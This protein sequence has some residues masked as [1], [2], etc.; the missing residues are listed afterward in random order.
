[1]RGY[2]LGMRLADVLPLVPDQLNRDTLTSIRQRIEPE[3]IEEALTRAKPIAVRRRKLPPDVVIWLMIGANLIAGMGFAELLR[4]LDLT[5]PTPR[6]NRQ[7]PA[8]SGAISDARRRVGDAVM[9][10]LFTIT[11]GHW[12]DLEDFERLRFH[13]LQV[14]ATDGFTIRTPDTDSNRT[15][16]GKPASRRDEAAY[17]TLNVVALMDVATHVLLDVELGGANTGEKALVMPLVGRIP[18]RS[19]TILDRG[20]DTLRLLHRISHRGDERHWLVRVQHPRVHARVLETLGD[21]DELIEIPVDRGVRRKAPELPPTFIARRVSYEVA[22]RRFT[23]MTSLTDARVYP[24][25]E[26][27]ALYHSRWE[28]EMAIDDIKNEQRD[29]AV[30]LRSKTP[31]GVRQELYALLLAHNLVRV[32]MARAAVLLRVR[33]TRISFHR[34]LVLITDEFRMLAEATPPSKWGD[35]EMRLRSELR[36]LLLPERRD[37]HFP[38]V[39][40]MPVGRYARKLPAASRAAQAAST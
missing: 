27:A 1:M 36:F 25:A 18:A 21:G 9:R 39:M 31:A 8:T 7:E 16:F 23:V 35:R 19:V 38:R 40:K 20:F 33:P 5:A 6:D 26:I 14:L 30:T 24:A 10:E 12:R 4:R 37:R 11:A 29:S 2:A 3:W 32:E 34:A 15:E 17:P 28:I 22:S 13:G